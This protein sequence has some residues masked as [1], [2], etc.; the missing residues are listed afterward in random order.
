MLVTTDSNTWIREYIQSSW[1]NQF[2]EASQTSRI[3]VS[4]Y[5]IDE[6]L[7]VAVNS[8]RWI[9]NGLSI[10]SQELTVSSPFEEVRHTG[11][12]LSCVNVSIN[13]YLSALANVGITHRNIVHNRNR[14][15]I[16]SLAISVEATTQSMNNSEHEFSSVIYNSSI[17]QCSSTRN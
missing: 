6:G 14:I 10:T 17:S 4:D 12:T 1:F 13:S 7:F 8:H 16:D 5:A 11:N 9:V 2:W 15:Y 3:L